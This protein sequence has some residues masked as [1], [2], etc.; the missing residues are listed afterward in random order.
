MGM[1]SVQK[2][3]S[4]SPGMTVEEVKAILGE[5]YSTQLSEDALILKFTL[6]ENWKGFV[7]YYFTFDK[8]SDKLVSWQADEAEYHRK[9]RMVI[10][11]MYPLLP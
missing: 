4:L 11:S 6:H 5:Q 7:P 8:E 3:N 2:L 10:L 9:S 1:N